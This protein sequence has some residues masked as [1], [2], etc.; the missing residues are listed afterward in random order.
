MHQK[1]LESSSNASK[2]S[3]NMS[4]GTFREVW[5]GLTKFDRSLTKTMTRPKSRF[6]QLFF[7]HWKEHIKT[8]DWILH[9]SKMDKKQGS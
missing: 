1:V 8:F 9:R 2:S 4:A 6:D 3:Q 7:D 5:K